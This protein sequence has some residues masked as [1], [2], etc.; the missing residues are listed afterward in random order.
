MESP[1]K[2]MQPVSERQCTSSG[3]DT[4]RMRR[5]LATSATASCACSLCRKMNLGGRM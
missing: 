1:W 2:L 4:P 3:V 5:C